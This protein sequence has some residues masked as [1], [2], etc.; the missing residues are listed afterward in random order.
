MT[1]RMNIA[2]ALALGAIVFT[3]GCEALTGGGESTEPKT[4]MKVEDVY[5]A[6]LAL[7]GSSQL[8]D[9]LLAD[10]AGAVPTAEE[11]AKKAHD[12]LQKSG[13]KCVTSSVAGAVLTVDFGAGCKPPNSQVVISGK[14]AATYVVKAGPPKSLEVSLVL[15]NF[16]AGDKSASGTG[17]LT[18]T[19]NATGAAVTVQ[20]DMTAGDAV[21]AGGITAD[22]FIDSASD[23]YQKVVFSTIDPTEVTVG[24]TKVAVVATKVT[25]DKDACYPSDGSVVGKS[26]SG[27]KFTIAFD[28]NTATSGTAKLTKPLLSTPVDQALPGIGWKCK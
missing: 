12:A 24:E 25:F 4:T 5:A 9:A 16:G 11:A 13:D 21:L 19:P 17:K 14:V 23:A 6:T 8:P 1:N 22:V 3:V 7:V 20:I 28:A 10:P 2:R 15:T 26:S 27:L 18:A